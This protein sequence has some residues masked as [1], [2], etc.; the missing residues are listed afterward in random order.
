MTALIGF[1][2]MQGAPKDWSSVSRILIITR[3]S[4]SIIL[5]ING[6]SPTLQVPTI[7]CLTRDYMHAADLVRKSVPCVSHSK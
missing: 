1:V 3:I 5:H 2:M 6:S 4:Y 7:F